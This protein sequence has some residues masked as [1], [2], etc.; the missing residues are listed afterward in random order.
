MYSCWANLKTNF[1]H[2]CLKCGI[3]DKSVTS[4]LW[5][6]KNGSS[7]VYSPKGTKLFCILSFSSFGYVLYS[8]F[9]NVVS[10]II[11]KINCLISFLC[12]M[13]CTLICF[14]L[15]Y[16]FCLICFV[17]WYVFVWYL[18]LWIWFVS[19]YVFSFDMLCDDMF[20]DDLK[21]LFWYV[22]LGYV[23]LWY[24][25]YALLMSDRF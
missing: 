21:I 2:K 4:S 16:V 22:S 11:E 13:F 17:L 20:R 3:S 14:V 7:L 18:S 5:K 8:D 12:D 24:V 19:W 25:L 6:W 15:W 9:Y 1:S 23:L 10:F